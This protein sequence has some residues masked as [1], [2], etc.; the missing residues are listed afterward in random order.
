MKC[1][2]HLHATVT[3]RI[4]KDQL[5]CNSLLIPQPNIRFLKVLLKF[6]NSKLSDRYGR[7]LIIC[8]STF[9]FYICHF[10]GIHMANMVI[11]ESKKV[12]YG[13]VEKLCQKKD[14]PFPHS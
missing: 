8:K 5:D 4:N 1:I 14:M 10:L 12:R 7:C 13:T 2:R 3:Y 11:S 6:E 9:T